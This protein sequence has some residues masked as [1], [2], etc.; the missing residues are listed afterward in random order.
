[1]ADRGPKSE[2]GKGNECAVCMEETSGS[3]NLCCTCYLTFGVHEPA[4]NPLCVFMT[5]IFPTP[6]KTKGMSVRFEWKT[7]REA[8]ICAAMLPVCVFK[9]VVER[10]LNFD[11][12]WT[13]C[14]G[15]I[16]Q[17]LQGQVLCCTC[18]QMLGSI[19]D[20]WSSLR[21]CALRFKH[22]SMCLVWGYP[23]LFY[24]FSLRIPFPPR[25]FW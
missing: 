19:H 17:C 23:F 18:Y 14:A 12:V 25:H 10:Q 5:V 1:M 15:D 9:T 16:C 4:S 21:Q 22:S 20:S 11:F 2:E 8:Q 24:V 3:T 13:V 7:L 6:N